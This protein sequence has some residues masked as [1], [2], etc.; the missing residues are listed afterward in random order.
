MDQVTE[1]TD[2]EEQ[3]GVQAEI[4]VP[5][6]TAP[7]QAHKDLKAGN[8]TDPDRPF[9]VF[10]FCGDYTMSFY[11]QE[12]EDGYDPNFRLDEISEDEE[13]DERP[14]KAELGDHLSLQPMNDSPDTRLCG[15]F[16][17]EELVGYLK[18]HSYDLERRVLT[19]IWCAQVNVYHSEFP[20]AATCEMTLKFSKTGL[21]FVGEADING[22]W[23]INILDGSQTAE[24]RG[25]AP[26]YAAAARDHKAYR[27][28]EDEDFE[29]LEDE[30]ASA[31]A[32]QAAQAAEP[33]EAAA[34]AE[35][36]EPMK[37]A[38]PLEPAE[39]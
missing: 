21:T 22:E 7:E 25:R 2:S 23:F 11:T 19:L 35:P 31:A 6:S 17:G 36:A 15:S 37:P 39:Q 38:E 24:S 27:E 14:D 18:S 32:A 20:E 9:S 33:A 16:N 29:W 12:M 28:R 30:E 34:L 10:D 5:E 1:V 26:D 4:E 13:P 3:A 8:A